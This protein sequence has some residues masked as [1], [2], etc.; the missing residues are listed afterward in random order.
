MT[1]IGCM[2]ERLFVLH[3]SLNTPIQS[4][5]YANQKKSDV[6]KAHFCNSNPTFCILA[7]F[8]RGRNWIN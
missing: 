3:N 8:K 4:A 5:L 6:F 7:E 1:N 2:R